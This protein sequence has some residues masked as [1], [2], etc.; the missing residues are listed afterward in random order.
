MAPSILAGIAAA[1]AHAAA[2]S[3]RL[4]AYGGNVEDV[5]G[6]LDAIVGGSRL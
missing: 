3:R 2:M 1:I 6:V 4:S 5:V